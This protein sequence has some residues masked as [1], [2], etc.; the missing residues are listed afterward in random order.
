MD[1]HCGTCGEPWDTY[2]MRHDAIYD[3]VERGTL[4]EREAKAWDGK[5]SIGIV[6]AFRD[7][8][9][10]FGGSIT[11]VTR[12]PACK[13][14]PERADAPERRAR[15]GILGELMP[16]DPDGIAAMQDD[17]PKWFR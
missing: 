15:L 16:D 8:G 13:T 5:L 14:Q 2:H 12:C 7:A 10:E 17:F 4:S 9:W 11:A 6:E 1:I 3:C